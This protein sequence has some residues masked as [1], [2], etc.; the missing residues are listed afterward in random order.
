MLL[1]D[2]IYIAHYSPLAD[3][4]KRLL[5]ILNE[6]HSDVEWVELEPTTADLSEYY[7][8]DETLWNSRIS[9]IYPISQ[10][11]YRPLKRAEI[12]IAYKQI[13]I[14]EKISFSDDDPGSTYIIFEDEILFE[15]HFVDSFNAAL[16]VSPRDW[17]VIFFGSGCDLHVP[18]NQAG[19]GIRSYRKDHPASRC[20]DSYIITKEAAERLVTTFKPFVTAYDYEL[21]YH[22]WKHD[23]TVYWWEP[24]LTR[25]GSQCGVYKSEI[26]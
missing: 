12:S 18:A 4:K 20:A 2:K 6:M 1:V 8:S 19:D 23:L 14:L 15:P 17:D 7:H 11:R 9:P 10:H 24:S 16:L 26:Q 13:K 3:R 5:S 22:M 21:A 25:Q